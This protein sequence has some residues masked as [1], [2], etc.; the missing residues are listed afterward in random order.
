MED[1][2]KPARGAG[3]SL[4]GHATGFSFRLAHNGRLLVGHASGWPGLDPASG[5]GGGTG[6]EAEPDGALIFGRFLLH[7]TSR[8]LLR[9]HQPV[10]LGSRTFDLFH[11]LLMSRGK[12]VSK[13][14]IFAHVWPDTRV[15]E[16]NLRVQVAL[17]RKILGAERDLL[18]TIP[19]RGYLL[20]DDM[21]GGIAQIRLNGPG[22]DQS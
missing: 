15:D 11:L 10:K 12:L 9:A 1:G 21:G 7:P 18:K 19:G 17:L 4:P 5:S 20:A 3:A 8:T 13:D 16:S 6:R 22:L 2:R 14:R